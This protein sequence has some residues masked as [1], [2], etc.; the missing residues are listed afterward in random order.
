MIEDFTKSIMSKPPL[1]SVLLA[2]YNNAPY[3]R[4]AIESV[5]LQ[6]YENWEIVVV[7]DA[8]T[9]DSLA[10]LNVYADD[11]R[12][13]VI[14][15]DQNRGCGYTKRRCA[16]LA[17]GELCAYLDPDDALLPEALETMVK[18]HAEHPE[19]ALV[20]SKYFHCDKRLNVRSPSTHQCASARLRATRAATPL[21]FWDRQDRG[22][23]DGTRW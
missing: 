5:R 15:N 22:P 21:R 19:C 12:I 10:V 13:R 6:P 23:R 3:L 17:R 20:Y 14:S 2:N 11:P 7:D 8:S 18:A 1:I 9:D 4:E 16:E